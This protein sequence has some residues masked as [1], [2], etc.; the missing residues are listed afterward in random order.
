MDELLSHSRQGEVMALLC[1]EP[2]PEKC[3]R[4]LVVERMSEREGDLQ[5]LH[6]T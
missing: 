1:S 3:H 5:V 4:R 6:L 2:T